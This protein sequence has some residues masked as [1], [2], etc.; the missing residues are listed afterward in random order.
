MDRTNIAQLPSDLASAMI[1]AML[2]HW[3][4]YAKR[5]A[6]TDEA[7][8]AMTARIGTDNHYL[9][10]EDLAAAFV[11]EADQWDALSL[12]VDPEPAEQVEGASI[13]WS[14]NS[15]LCLLKRKQYLETKPERG[16]MLSLR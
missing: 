12:L 7:I 11:A 9:V 10:D 14:V 2:D 1:S 15:T 6:L 13:E 16:L 8:E 3:A 4:K 5:P